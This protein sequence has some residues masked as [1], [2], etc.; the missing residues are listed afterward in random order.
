MDPEEQ[1]RALYDGLCAEMAA[2]TLTLAAIANAQTQTAALMQQAGAPFNTYGE[3]L[4]H[5]KEQ[6][7]ASTPA[8]RMLLGLS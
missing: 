8:G 6:L 5:L 4:Y 2:G 7:L 3:P 1:A